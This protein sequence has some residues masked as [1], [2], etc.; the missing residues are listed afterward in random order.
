[1][2]GGVFSLL[3]PRETFSINK[4]TRLAVWDSPQVWHCS[5]MPTHHKRCSPFCQEKKKRENP[6]FLKMY[7]SLWPVISSTDTKPLNIPWPPPSHLQT[8]LTKS[9]IRPC[10]THTL[11][12]SGSINSEKADETVSFSL[13]IDLSLVHTFGFRRPEL[14]TLNILKRC[15]N[16]EPQTSQSDEAQ[17]CMLELKT[18]S[19]QWPLE[20]L[21]WG[22]SREPS[23]FKW[24]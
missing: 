4:M 1:M 16:G 7:H 5:C 15:V 24:E 21:G 19:F 17:D 18:W 3:R 9:L 13:Y 22:G 23:L 2:L 11:P 10:H 6:A 20:K 12:S 14:C 8:S